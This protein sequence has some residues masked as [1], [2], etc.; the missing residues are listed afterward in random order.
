MNTETKTSFNA[1]L[2]TSEDK[3][4]I[5]DLRNK[6]DVTEKQLMSILIAMA[7]H[8]EADVAARAADVNNN[9]VAAR[10]AQKQAK[11]QVRE[12]EKLQ[13]KQLRAEAKQ[14]KSLAKKEA[15]EARAQAREQAKQA[16]AVEPKATKSK[17]KDSTK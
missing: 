12:A 11:L 1:C 4:I 9:I 10:E 2:V 3:Q 14:Q 17:A 7:V 16:K 5:Q 6:Y 13:R 15:A 8:N